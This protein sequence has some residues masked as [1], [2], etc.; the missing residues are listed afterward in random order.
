MHWLAQ[1]LSNLDRVA[2]KLAA[3]KT[4]GH[5]PADEARARE[6]F[7]ATLGD[8]AAGVA[9]R[10][11]VTAAFVAHDG[12]V[13]AV[14]GNVPSFDALAATAQV[15][16]S[17]GK[18]A[19]TSLSLGGLRQMVLIGEDHKLALFLLGQMALGILAPSETNLAATLGE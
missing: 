12:L 7:L 18:T 16:M 5:R 9:K 4:E 8:L 17:A 1:Q 11:G 13:V 3:T 2:A 10:R 14:A 19:A 6:S 15:C